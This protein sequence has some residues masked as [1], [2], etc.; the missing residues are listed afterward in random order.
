M[1]RLAKVVAHFDEAEKNHTLIAIDGKARAIALQ[2]GESAAVI[3]E[4][5]ERLA[6]RLIEI[7]AEYSAVLTLLQIH[8]GPKTRRAITPLIESETW[9]QPNKNRI[10]ALYDAIQEELYW[11]E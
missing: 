3:S 8:F 10:N 6:N 1:E 5:S 11:F 7:E 2:Q 9:F 4:M